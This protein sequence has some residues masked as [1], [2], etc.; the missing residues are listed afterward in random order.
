MRIGP[1]AQEMQQIMQIYLPIPLR[2][3]IGGQVHARQFAGQALLALL[4]DHLF[5]MVIGA[6]RIITQIAQHALGL[7][8]RQRR[9]PAL[10][11][12]HRLR[13]QCLGRGDVK[14]AV[15]NRIARGIFVYIGGAM[16]DPLTRHENRQLHMQLDLAHL[17]RGRMPMPHQIADKPLVILHRFGAFAVRHTRR[18]ANGGIIAH[19][20]DHPHKPMIQHRNGRIKMLL[21]PRRD[22]PQSGLGLG[23]QGI[24]FGL[25]INGKR[26]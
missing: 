11:I 8:A 9:T 25:L 17:E 6:H 5:V 7:V 12:H 23:A 3:D 21:D 10:V 13:G 18:L 2:I 14:L 16:A 4:A 22:R 20:I 15:Q 1:Q 24:D 19:V 26:H